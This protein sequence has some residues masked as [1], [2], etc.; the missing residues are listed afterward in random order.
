M[1]GRDR[2]PATGKPEAGT[3]EGVHTMGQQQL[4]LVILGV[5]MVGIAIAVGISLF[6]ESAVS[7]NRDAVTHDL[8]N[9]AGRAQQYYRRATVMGGGGNTFVGLTADLAG[10]RKLT[11]SPTTANGT[12]SILTAGTATGLVMQGIGT[13]Y[14]EGTDFVTVEIHVFNDGTDSVVVVH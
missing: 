2:V 14:A 9:L 6:A 13:E 3:R 8:L 5:I 12:Y 7:D 11:N 10:I 4:L 1:R